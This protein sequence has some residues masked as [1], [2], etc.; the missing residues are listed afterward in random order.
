M[1]KH[2][3]KHEFI[4]KKI[5][6]FLYYNKL[7]PM[8]P[9]PP[10]DKNQDKNIIKYVPTTN[11]DKQ[12]TFFFKFWGLNVGDIDSEKYDDLQRNEEISVT[13]SIIFI[14]TKHQTFPIKNDNFIVKIISK[15]SRK[16]LKIIY[17][18]L[19]AFFFSF[20]EP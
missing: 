10:Q 20:L 4:L 18:L 13:S 1:R 11:E 16:R 8:P 9:L 5:T 7:D 15:N 19:S 2:E 17:C 14:K 3:Y 6:F 12:T